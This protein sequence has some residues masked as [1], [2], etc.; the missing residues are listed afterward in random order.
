[1]NDKW[2]EDVNST[3]RVLILCEMKTKQQT[4]KEKP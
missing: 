3:S 2:L 4:N 1:M